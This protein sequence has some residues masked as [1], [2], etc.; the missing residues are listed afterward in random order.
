M[1]THEKSPAPNKVLDACDR[2]GRDY[3]RP[4]EQFVEAQPRGETVNLCDEC[5]SKEQCR[6]C[7]SVIVVTVN[8]GA[9]RDGECNACEYERYRSQPD[10]VTALRE[11]I[12]YVEL[13]L[14][15]SGEDNGEGKMLKRWKKILNAAHGDAA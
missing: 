4:R 7:G 5:K 12:T 1:S 10:L 6:T 2:C 8:D 9:F 15:S 3:L 14:D 11:A 13:V